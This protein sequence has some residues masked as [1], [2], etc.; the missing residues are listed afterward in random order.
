MVESSRPRVVL[1]MDRELVR[2]KSIERF[3][4]DAV[5]SSLAEKHAAEEIPADDPELDPVAERQLE[6]GFNNK[7]MNHTNVRSAILER[8]ALGRIVVREADGFGVIRD[9]DVMRETLG[10]DD[11]ARLL[12]DE[13]RIAIFVSTSTGLEP[14]RVTAGER[15][16]VE[17]ARPIAEAL[18][19]KS[20][21]PAEPVHA[22]DT[23]SKPAKEHEPPPLTTPD[24]ADAFDGINETTATQWR[25]WLG[26]VNNH[27]WLLPARAV[28]ASTPKSAT[29]WPLV[30]A[31]LLL[32]RKASGDS[33]N[34]AFLTMPMLKPR[35]KLWQE[36]R[37]ERNAFGQ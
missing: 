32:E 31:S 8:R 34:R 3:V 4:S 19:A 17:P 13:W 26:D 24:I 30:F 12:S 36:Q 11:F 20:V 1:P 15:S 5:L 35:L 18:P 37:R 9:D 33:L 10:R 28:K 22:E 21:A 23:S 27:E 7:S 2:I 6:P 16:P 25:N 29:W 14:V